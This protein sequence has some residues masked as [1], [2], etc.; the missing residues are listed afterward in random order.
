MPPRPLRPPDPLTA[1]DGQGLRVALTQAFRAAEGDEAEQRR[2][3]LAILRDALEV[4][5]A[6]AER[7]LA[8]HGGVAA[9]QALAATADA[10]VQALYAFTTLHVARASNPTEGERLAL[11]AV[12]GYGRGALAPHSDIDL[13]FLRAYK[14]SPHTESVVEYMLYALWDL[15]LKVGHASRTA[16]ESLKLAEADTTIK[17]ALVDARL[18]AGDERLAK[19]LRRA[20]RSRAAEDGAAFVAAKLAERDQRHA[21]SGASRYLVEPNVKESK[22]GLRDIH[23]LLWIAGYLHPD[24]DRLDVERR[25]KGLDRREVEALWRAA[26]FLWAVRI[27]LHLAAG[28]AQERLTFDWQPEIARRMGFGDGDAA[29]VKRLMRRYFHTARVVGAVTRAFC[30]ELEA[31]QAKARPSGL[32]RFLPPIDLRRAARLAPGF[33]ERAGRLDVDGPKTFAKRPAELI[34]L[35]ALADRRDLDLHPH[36]VATV[37]R[38]LHLITG[39]ARRDPL[40]VRLFI[41][42]LARGRRRYRSLSLMNETGV[43]GRFLP[44]FGRI[45]GES[46]FDRHHAYTVDEHTLRAVDV[47]QQI[48]RGVLA[49]EHPLATRLMPR[50]QDSEALYLAMLLHD[51]GKGQQGGQEKAGARAA[52]VACLRLG[53]SPE[54]ADLVAWLVGNH[55]LMSDVAQK[56]DV[57]DPATVEAFGAK[58]ADVERLRLLLILTVAD[59]RAVAPGVWNAWK[60]QL[61]RELFAATEAKLSGDL[62]ADAAHRLAKVVH[63]HST[64]VKRAGGGVAAEARTDTP[65]GVTRLA[66]AATDRPGLFADL[67]AT[68][69]AHGAQVLGA[70]AHTAP[71]GRV[72]DLFQLQDASGAPFGAATANAL[73]RLIAALEAE[74]RPPP[75][76]PSRRRVRG[77]P[78][79]PAVTIDQMA[80]ADA[81]LVEA[82]GKDRPGLLAEIARAIS[83]AG[84]SIRSAHVSSYGARAV[85]AFYLQRPGGGK[86][87]EAEARVLRERLLTV[88]EPQGPRAARESAAA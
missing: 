12:G 73:P 60:G 20:F 49:E 22:G 86:L 42:L 25:L 14:Q 56:R 2:L 75:L 53:L 35:F 17:T 30:A 58:V 41:D 43:L 78:A 74:E 11:L 51:V 67:A 81:T 19:D 87:G 10:V 23:T 63:D 1:I 88:L 85:D 29:S 69:A 68:L 9:A 33:V 13:L 8:S 76:E 21:R 28:R 65:A 70:E 57:S 18:L 34:R 3:A 59:I 71:D 50:L 32:S 38:S 61:L 6:K 48:G 5:R 44:E 27:H 83:D 62:A 4:G 7:R 82:S 15:G 52:R 37:R 36:A 80:S 79:E 84:V 64:L 46:Q 72:L 45:V 77:A 66:V 24:K 16:E 55:L 26:D 54:R 40:A 39:E 47:L 31:E